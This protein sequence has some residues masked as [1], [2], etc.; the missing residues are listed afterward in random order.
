MTRREPRPHTRTVSAREQ[1]RANDQPE[2]DLTSRD[3]IEWR[4]KYGERETPE[5]EAYLGHQ[6]TGQAGGK[7]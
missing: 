2:P 5:I 4:L 7:G 1:E 6:E 3:D